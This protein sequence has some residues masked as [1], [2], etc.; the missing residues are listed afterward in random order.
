[1]NGRRIAWAIR[2][3]INTKELSVECARLLHE[4]MLISTLVYGGE[5]MIWKAVLKSKIKAVQIDNLRAVIGM[6]SRQNEK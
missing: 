6:K 5:T 3:L 1:M 2:A 4:T